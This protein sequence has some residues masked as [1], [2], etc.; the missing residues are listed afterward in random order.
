MKI[1]QKFKTISDN[2]E[3]S[4]IPLSYFIFTFIFS[5]TLRNLIEYF[6]NFSIEGGAVSGPFYLHCYLFYISIALVI[7]FLLRIATKEK[8]EKIARM[9]L[10]LFF[11]LII[12]PII[13]LIISHGGGLKMTYLLPGFHANLLLRFFTLGG[14][15]EQSGITPGQKA[16][17]I[18]FLLIGFVYF[19]NKTK[20]IF[21]SLFYAFS[22]YS[23][24][25]LFALLPFMDKW[26]FGFLGI[27]ISLNNETLT[28]LLA[29]VGTIFGLAIVYLEYKE[30]L[31]VILKDI[32]LSRLLYYFSIFALG[33]AIAI[34]VSRYEFATS[35]LLNIISVCLSIFFAALYS[36][37]TNNIADYDIDAISNPDRPLTKKNIEIG[38][39]KKLAI[40]FLFLSLFYSAL[41]SFMI[42][43]LTV[44]YIGNYFIYSMPPLRL[45]RITFFSKLI[46]AINSLA[47]A[48]MGY[49][50]IA[51]SFRGF[52]NI[53]YL[54]FI[55]GITATAN[56]IDIKDYEGDK[57]A[58]IRTL[59]VVL[60]QINA[61]IVIGSFFLIAYPSFYIF[62]ISHNYMTHWFWIFIFLG[63]VQF[64]VINR[65][66]Y[67]DSTVMA[68]NILF[69][70]LTIYLLFR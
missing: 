17:I 1:F 27:Q 6:S 55:I 45:K 69:V 41:V 28:I 25:F 14:A 16:E 9:V 60:G 24:I 49:S 31:F 20:K 4:S 36:I 21:I 62:F 3:N 63:A 22:L 61:K 8:V 32:R 13:D 29:L 50:L 26:F 11:L 10:P 46:I 51:G 53:L 70:W 42:F 15:H 30:Y 57:Q 65:R 33:I 12:A 52:P 35:T 40:L 2:L 34:K 59:P 64:L 18:I 19:Y 56:F 48:L 39:Y 66:R 68:F 5:I 47:I 38:L 7:I 44:F 43:F 23:V 58:G 37:F 67:K 54:L